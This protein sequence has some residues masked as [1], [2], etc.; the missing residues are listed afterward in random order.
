[1]E[2][3]LDFKAFCGMAEQFAACMNDYL[4]VYDIINDAF[5]ITESA[6]ERFDLQRCLFH[7]VLNNLKNF[8]YPDDFPM[9]EADLKLLLSGDK[10]E[11]EMQYRWMGKNGVPIWIVCKGRVVLNEEGYPGLM[12]GCINE[13]GRTQKAD[14]VSGLLRASSFQ[15]HLAQQSSLTE[16][17][18]LRI[19]IDDFR[20][21][22]ERLGVEYGDTVLRQ[23]AQCIENCLLPE[24]FV[25]RVISDEFL[26][27]D[28]SGTGFEEVKELYCNIR[29][30]VEG[31]IARR[32]YEAVYTISGGI[33]SIQDLQRPD[34]EEI[35]R[36]SEFALGQAK[37][38]GK[39][40][41]YMFTQADYTAF[42]RTRAIS[43]SLR[44]AVSNDFAGLDL[45]FQPLVYTHSEELYGA[46]ALLRYQMPDG[47]R[48][49]PVEFIPLLEESGLILPV[50]K[51]IIR[52]AADMC[53]ICREKYPD[54]RISINLSYIQLTKSPV[55]VEV[56]DAL[57]ETRLPPDALIMELTESGYLEN[58]INVQKVW[59]RFK[60]AGV[61]IALDDF[62]TG[63]SNLQN[64]ARFNP[65]IVKIDRSFTLKAL[66]NSYERQ[67]LSHIINM[68]HSINLRIVIEGIEEREEQQQVMLLGSDFIQGY[69]YSKPCPRE[70]FLKKYRVVE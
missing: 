33:I 38:M 61:Q 70:E 11:H 69:Y 59:R 51:W 30:E 27:L 43:R 57:K 6:A 48:I 8:V 21:I 22:N 37:R 68:V 14:N 9:L 18:V 39:N 46:E 41:V 50:G 36:L 26:I 2:K 67:L 20:I 58:S 5:F 54:F 25:Y 45:Y 23:V 3:N 17:F 52:K 56:M 31:A 1:M 49:S 32:N 47:E 34:Y 53:R 15:E 42:L 16:G 62:G 65:D 44:K 7:D 10:T 28:L 13:I 35:M 4:Y 40:Q 24:Q 66:Q 55:F 60:E 63:Y 19:G 29:L 64:I 12:L